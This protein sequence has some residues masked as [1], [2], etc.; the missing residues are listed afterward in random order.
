MIIEFDGKKKYMDI[1]VSNIN[2]DG[3][4]AYVTNTLFEIKNPGTPQEER[5]EIKKGSKQS[6]IASPQKMII[7][8]RG[9]KSI[10]LVSLHGNIEKDKIYRL[11]IKPVTGKIDS[12]DALVR[13]LI[14]FDSLIIIRPKDPK[15]TYTV[16]REGK[17][18]TVTNTGNT[19]FLITEGK[20]CPPND[21]EKCQTLVGARIY[22]GNNKTYE[23]PTDDK[24]ELTFNILGRIEK[25]NY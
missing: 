6:L 11:S 4:K 24:V 2:Q 1:P 7:P 3:A 10:R 21:P 18:L 14:A 13:V 25:K 15:P 5:M 16:R 22:A 19:N 8:Y 9:K 23:I 12:D 20:Q 17:K